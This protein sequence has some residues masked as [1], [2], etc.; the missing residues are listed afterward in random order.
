[1]QL[2][3]R[4]GNGET[5]SGVFVQLHTGTR[6][7]QREISCRAGGTQS[8]ADIQGSGGGTN[9]QI[10]AAVN[11]RGVDADVRGADRNG[12]SKNERHRASRNRRVT[13]M[14]R[15]QRHCY[16]E[17]RGG[18]RKTAAHIQRRTRHRQGQRAIGSNGRVGTTESDTEV[19]QRHRRIFQRKNGTHCDCAGIGNGYAIE[20]KA[21][22]VNFQVGQA[23]GDVELIKG[24][25]A[26]T[27]LNQ[28]LVRIAVFRIVSN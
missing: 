27:N 20:M 12:S 16:G 17:G 26:G 11:R 25:G 21:I 14:R 4:H 13:E 10:R 5:E 3:R 6:L 24:N 23:A 28:L 1:M 22:L 19:R 2:T 8:R 18:R 9:G 7:N 15:I